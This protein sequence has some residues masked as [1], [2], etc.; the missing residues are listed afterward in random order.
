MEVQHLFYRRTLQG[1]RRLDVTQHAAE[2]SKD[3]TKGKTETKWKLTKYILVFFKR[4]D[5]T[6]TN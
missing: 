2:Q 3:V 4:G 5:D 1:D 6:D